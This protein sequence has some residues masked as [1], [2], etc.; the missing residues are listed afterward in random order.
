VA[1][2]LIVDDEVPINDLLAINLNLV[3]H[4]PVQAYDGNEALKLAESR[5]FDLC[6]LDV[7]LP[8][9]DGFELLPYLKKLGVPV[10]FLTARDSLSDRV[11]GLRM[12]ADDYITKPFESVE[13][14]ARVDAVL[15]RT[16]R[17]KNSELIGDVKIDFDEHRVTKN[18][19]PVKLAAKEF[20]LLE[21]LVKN[22]NIALTR[23]QLINMVWEYEYIGETR[24]VDMH[25][26]RLRKK[27]G[28]ENVIR[29][30]YKYGYRLER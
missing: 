12:G 2:I 20:A 21:V 5:A 16:G 28:F 15:R 30:V 22:A 1:Q 9:L 19:R 23:D 13:M 8:G 3:G 10:I 26:Q 11:K 25:I 24:T 14:L 6:L 18:G 4:I 17:G 29:T 7:M 27:L